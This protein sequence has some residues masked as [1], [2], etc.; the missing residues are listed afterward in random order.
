M[1]NRPPEAE[2]EALRNENKRLRKI[3]SQLWPVVT[4]NTKVG[5]WGPIEKEIRDLNRRK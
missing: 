5:F 2:M 4:R 1:S 3:I